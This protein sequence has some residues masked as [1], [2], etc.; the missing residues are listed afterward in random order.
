MMIMMKMKMEKALNMFEKLKK[1]IDTLK[2]CRR[3]S[4]CGQSGKCVYTVE[5]VEKVFEML[6]MLNKALKMLGVLKKTFSNMRV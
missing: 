1:T 3:H 2:N 6:K 5:I 4:K